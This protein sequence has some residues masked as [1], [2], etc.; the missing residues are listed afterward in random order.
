MCAHGAVLPTEKMDYIKPDLI[1]S[2][3]EEKPDSLDKAIALD[4]AP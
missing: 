3:L 4:S 1:I 2:Q